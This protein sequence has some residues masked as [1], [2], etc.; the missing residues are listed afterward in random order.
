LTYELF[1]DEEGKKISKSVGKGLT[2]DTWVQYAPIESLLYYIYQNPKRARRLFWDVVPK[3][4]DDYLA[5]LSRYPE[6]EEDKR[7]EQDVWHIGNRGAE[8]PEYGAQVNF[9]MA[10]NLISALGA[11]EAELLVDY[12]ERYDESAASYPDVTR[13]LV[14]KGLN[15]YR[16][17]ILP[18]KKFRQPNAEERAIFEQLV[19]KLEG[20]EA[21]D[22]GELQAIPF[23]IARAAEMEPKDLFRLFY[24]V[25]LGQERGP[26][27]GSFAKMVGVEKVREMVREKVGVGA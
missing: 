11:D 8:V 9:S 13:S 22:E 21:L 12:I 27:F 23:D 6:I 10:N 18:N 1:L 7:P 2:V 5:A 16:D 14:E 24:E 17:F 4:V 25:V 3:C 26:R 20:A 15:Y 19:D